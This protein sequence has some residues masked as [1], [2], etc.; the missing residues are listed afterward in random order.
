MENRTG[1]D[2]ILATGAY[3]SE[4]G[5]KGG[6]SIGGANGKGGR[7]GRG[8]EALINHNSASP[9]I[10]I[11]KLEGGAGGQG[12]TGTIAGDAGDGGNARIKSEEERLLSKTRS[13]G[14]DLT[15]KKFGDKY[16]LSDDIVSKLKSLGYAN[17]SAL[18]FATVAELKDSHFKQGEINELKDA[19]DRWS[20]KN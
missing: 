14:P 4:V 10:D 3:V 19:L 8:A 7:G 11:G 20:P 13:R 1:M 5:G 15:I 6:D 18:R 2:A 17:A 12:G 16:S 9:Y